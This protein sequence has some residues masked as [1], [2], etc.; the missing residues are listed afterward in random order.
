MRAPV[1][2]RVERGECDDIVRQFEE[3]EGE[4]LSQARRVYAGRAALAEKS[5]VI[6]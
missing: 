5:I 6:H 2:V 1:I 4:R 3:I